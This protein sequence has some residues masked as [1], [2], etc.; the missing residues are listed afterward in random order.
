[1]ETTEK[2]GKVKFTFE[3]EINQSAMELIK[4]NVNMMTDIAGQAAQN[5]R[6]EMARRR[7]EGGKQGGHGMGMMMHHSQE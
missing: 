4:E 3:M 6:E 2:P 5:W 1:M 7:K